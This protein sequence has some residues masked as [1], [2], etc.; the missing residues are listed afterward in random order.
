MIDRDHRRRQVEPRPSARVFAI[1]A[2]RGFLGR[3]AERQLGLEPECFIDQAVA[4]DPANANLQLYAGI[5]ESKLGNHQKAVEHYTKAID[6]NPDFERAYLSRALAYQEMGNTSG[7]ASDME[8]A[9]RGQ[10]SEILANTFLR[11]AASSLKAGRVGATFE[12]L[13]NAERLGGNRCAIAYYRGDAYYQL[14][15]ANEGEDK[16]IAQNEKARGHFQQAVTSLQNACGEYTSYA[17]GLK[18]NANQYITRVDAIIKKL[19]RGG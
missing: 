13:N 4:A 3:A 17:D 5:V 7:F 11:E 14:G 8:K 15:R 10:S 6:I 18:S 9:G 16:S 19:S 1:T 2:C 12:A